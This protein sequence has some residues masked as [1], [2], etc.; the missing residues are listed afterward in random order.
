MYILYD[1]FDNIIACH[2]ELIVVE[3]YQSN[4]KF[5][6][7]I[8]SHIKYMKDKKAV[9]KFGNTLYELE[10]TAY[11]ETYVPYKY[12]DYVNYNNRNKS[13]ELHN[14]ENFFLVQI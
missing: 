3:E 12:I 14:F 6:H 7:E 5:H 13:R 10:L 8:K 4:L 11:K 9:K 2:E 1:E